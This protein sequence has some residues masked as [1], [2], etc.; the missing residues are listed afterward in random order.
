MCTE[1]YSV[2]VSWTTTADGW[3][4]GIIGCLQF[5]IEVVR[6]PVKMIHLWVEVLKGL[7]KEGHTKSTP[8]HYLR[9]GHSTFVSHQVTFHIKYSRLDFS[10]FDWSWFLYCCNWEA[11]VQHKLSDQQWSWQRDRCTLQYHCSSQRQRISNPSKAS[12]IGMK[13]L[14][15]Y[16]VRG[17]WIRMGFIC[18]VRRLL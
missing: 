4:W 8:T 6:C 5:N 17:C 1:M 3:K 12:F 7:F 14:M 15:A 2:S 10:P 13:T 18:V 11:C 9:W 16:W